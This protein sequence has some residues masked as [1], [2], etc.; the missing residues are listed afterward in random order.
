MIKGEYYGAISEIVPLNSAFKRKITSTIEN[1]YD[2]VTTTLKQT[3]CS[4]WKPLNPEYFRRLVHEMDIKIDCDPQ[5]CQYH[6][7][8]EKNQHGLN[9]GETKISYLSVIF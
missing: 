2:D 8:W 9:L 5:V 3:N 7:L 4:G 1:L 6:R